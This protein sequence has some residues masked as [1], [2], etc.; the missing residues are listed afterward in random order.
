MIIFL[1][2]LI[3]RGDLFPTAAKLGRRS[4]KMRE[5]IAEACKT[6]EDNQ[7]AQALHGLLSLKA[8]S[9]E[10]IITLAQSPVTE[11]V[12]PSP[13][14]TQVHTPTTALSPVMTQSTLAYT[15]GSTLPGTASSTLVEVAQHVVDGTAP[16]KNLLETDQ[17][18]MNSLEKARI[19]NS[20]VMN[21][22]VLSVFIY[23]MVPRCNVL[24]IIVIIGCLF[25]K[26]SLKHNGDPPM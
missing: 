1:I 25:Y 13:T 23:L 17:L 9:H 14:L 2:S 19:C 16:Q 21:V 12:N 11:A 4:R 20:E 18:L 15:H 5:I 22:R 8:E 6:I 3:S 10:G 24:F 26:L 7:T